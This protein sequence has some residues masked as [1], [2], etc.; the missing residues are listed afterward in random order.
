MAKKCKCPPAGAP[1]WMTTYA[2]M[3]TLLLCF[4]VLIVSFSEIKEEDQYQAVVEEI[5]EAFG[6]KGG[7]GKLPTDDD[8]ALSFIQILETTRLRDEKII[9]RSNAED[10]GIDGRERTVKTVREGMEF[11]IDG[12]RITFDPGSAV[13]T[14]E[15]KR[16]LDQLADRMKGY[17]NVIE[18]RGHA[19][20]SDGPRDRLWDV[21]YARARSVFDYL[22]SDQVG[23][24]RNRFRLAANADREPLNPRAYNSGEQIP[25]RRVEI[26]VNEA[27]VSELTTPEGGAI[28]AVGP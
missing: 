12:G 18:L 27:L 4:F 13:L 9:H 16:A 15:V 14:P 17:N 5:K 10:P 22:T 6:M 1:E 8:P 20:S 26:I 19:A 23:I 28:A 3:M 24:D 21:S 11:P 7:G 2:D 25:N